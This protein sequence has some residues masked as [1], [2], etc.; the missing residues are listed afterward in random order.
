M[1]VRLLACTL[2]LGVGVISACGG[3]ADS[4]LFGGTGGDVADSGSGSDGSVKH[5]GGVNPDGGANPDADTQKDG[6]VTHD[7]SPTPDAAPPADTVKCEGTPG[8][9]VG[10]DACCR[11]S[12]GQT[13]YSC[14]PL[15]SCNGGGQTLEIPCD[16]AR[17][18]E[19][20]GAPGDVCCVTAAMTSGASEVTC[21]PASECTAALGRT[22]LCDPQMAGACTQGLTCQPSQSTIP[23][24]YICR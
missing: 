1:S 7:A 17:D 16:K 13:S 12:N 19:L 20:L 9:Q 23:G 18:C 6:A 24:Y 11:V 5:D 15:G 10:T 2:V 21:R 22:N 3:A 14:V 8:C 4:G